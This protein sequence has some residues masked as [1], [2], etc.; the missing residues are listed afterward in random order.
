MAHVKPY[1]GCSRGCA[2]HPHGSSG[3]ATTQRTDRSRVQRI[4]GGGFE[5]HQDHQ[6][7]G[8]RGM[9]RFQGGGIVDHH[10]QAEPINREPG[11]HPWNGREKQTAGGAVKREGEHPGK[12]HGRPGESHSNSMEERNTVRS[13]VA[14]LRTVRP[15]PSGSRS[16]PSL[17]THPNPSTPQPGTQATTRTNTHHAPANKQ[18]QRLLGSHSLP[19]T[20]PAHTCGDDGGLPSMTPTPHPPDHSGALA[21]PAPTVQRITQGGMHPVQ[22]MRSN[23]QRT[24]Q[25][26][27]SRFP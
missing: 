13:P 1:R 15:P 12:A 10:L 24:A 18:R 21:P 8:I 27:S 16:P 14:L 26:T 9:G 11:E 5:H 2:P 3:A 25:T 20:H 7:S 19:G 23:P 22:P 17:N 4:R 6:E